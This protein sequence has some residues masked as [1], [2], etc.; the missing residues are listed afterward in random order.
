MKGLQEKDLNLIAKIFAFVS[1]II[2]FTNCSDPTEIII[3]ND[4]IPEEQMIGVLVDMH[5]IE[6]GKVGRKMMGDTLVV[7]EYFYKVYKKHEIDKSLFDKSFKFYS[8]HPKLMDVLYEKVI[9]ELN[10]KQKSAPKW[11]DKKGERNSLER[12]DTNSVSKTDSL[13]I[14]KDSLKTVVK[15]SLVVDSTAL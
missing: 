5:L 6:G 1:C 7:D 3:P 8:G 10:H 15:D 4:I 2:L 12:K 9:E 13:N 11:N 14:S